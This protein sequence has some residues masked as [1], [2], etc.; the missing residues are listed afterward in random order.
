MFRLVNTA[1]NGI[2]REIDAAA[3]GYGL[4]QLNE[5]HSYCKQHHKI[6]CSPLTHFAVSVNGRNHNNA[7]G[8]Y[9]REP[10]HSVNTYSV[11]VTP[12]FHE[13]T[14]NAVKVEYQFKCMLQT[15]ERW[16]TPV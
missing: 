11:S 16:I 9:I 3:R 14:D 10:L 6:V 15:E 2:L 1:N 12:V 5:A 13:D 8:I 4:L 7:R